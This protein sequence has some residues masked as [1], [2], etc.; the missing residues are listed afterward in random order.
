[1]M[2]LIEYDDAVELTCDPAL[3][4]ERLIELF[5]RL[6]ELLEDDSWETVH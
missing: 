4:H 2:V 1:M 3:T 6:I 5:E